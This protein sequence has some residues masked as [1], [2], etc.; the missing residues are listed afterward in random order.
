MGIKRWTT[1]HKGRT[2]FAFP[3]NRILRRTL[4]QQ[5][6][7]LWLPLTRFLTSSPRFDEYRSVSVL[8]TDRVNLMAMVRRSFVQKTWKKPM[9]LADSADCVLEEF[10]SFDADF[11]SSCHRMARA[12]TVFPV[13]EN[14]HRN[15]SSLRP[16]YR[17]LAFL[18]V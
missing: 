6:S 17:K 11:Q 8:K 14:I 16:S 1:P 2:C 10:V 13:Q 3:Q 5:G 12:V 15:N 18:M 4:F 7:S 9:L